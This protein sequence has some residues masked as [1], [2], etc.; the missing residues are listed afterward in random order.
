MTQ[1][2]S[3]FSN[4]GRNTL[5]D[6]LKG[7]AT[8]IANADAQG[9]ANANADEQD[10][11]NANKP[12]DFATVVDLSKEVQEI[13]SLESDQAV[14]DKLEALVQGKSSRGG[15]A[16]GAFFGATNAEAAKGLLGTSAVST[17]EPQ[18]FDR[19]AA[20]QTAAASG[21]EGHDFDA[22]IKQARLGQ[23]EGTYGVINA[24]PDETQN[25]VQSTLFSRAIDLVRLEKQG[26]TEQAQKLYDA[27]TNGT[28]QIE[29]PDQVAELDLSYTL[30]RVQNSFGWS[31][32]WT[33]DQTA[34]G[35]VK[36]AMDS[37]L[38]TTHGQGEDGAYY[39]DWS[40]V[41]KTA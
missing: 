11:T 25:F 30:S 12:G 31:G 20:L 3:P 37:G 22:L 16:A 1:M 10:T 28:L 9:T 6:M 19:L 39:F 34:S 17:D 5:I 41:E 35:A 36:A 14:A 18:I 2:L 32:T 8:G 27:V 21:F 24:L 40:G 13:L 33:L 38:A 15:N 29:D 23:Q 26:K 7:S 4:S